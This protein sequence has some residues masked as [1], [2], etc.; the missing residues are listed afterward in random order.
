MLAFEFEEKEKI[1]A[2]REEIHELKDIMRNEL[3]ELEKELV[4]AWE[5]MKKRKLIRE[6]KEFD[7]KELELLEEV[8]KI[9]SESLV[10]K[11]RMSLC[12]QSASK[13]QTDSFL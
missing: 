4:V 9:K 5:H 7:S 2:D 3:T 1:A 10:R 6:V 12:K 11:R 8:E 13:K